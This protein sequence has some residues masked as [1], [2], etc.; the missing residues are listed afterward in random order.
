MGRRRKRLRQTKAVAVG[1]DFAEP[2][3]VAFAFANAALFTAYIV[4]AHRVSRHRQLNRV[5]GLALAMLLAFVFVGPLGAGAAADAFTDP[6][7]LAA[8]AGVALRPR[9]LG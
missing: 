2:V 7:A 3:G 5:N 6:V 9:L 8:A 4:M 1:C